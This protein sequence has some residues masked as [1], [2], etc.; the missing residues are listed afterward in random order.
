MDKSNPIFIVGT[1]RSGTTLLSMILNKHSAIRISPETHFFFE[2]V[3]RKYPIT[4]KKLVNQNEI[5]ARRLVNNPL[6]KDFKKKLIEDI[7]FPNFDWSQDSLSLLDMQSSGKQFLE[8][9]LEH[10]AVRHNKTVFGEKTPGH[11]FFVPSIKQLF[12]RAKIVHIIRDPRAV[13][14]STRKAWPMNSDWRVA[15]SLDCFS[16]EIYTKIGAYYQTVYPRDYLEMRYETLLMEPER[17]I[18]QLCAFLN[19]EFEPCMVNDGYKIPPNFSLSVE[20]WK[21]KSLEPID[22]SRAT[23]WTTEMPAEEQRFFE[24]LLGSKLAQRGFHTTRQDFSIM[25]RVRERL[26]MLVW[27]VRRKWDKWRNAE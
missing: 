2:C 24:Q 13:S 20:P 26:L 23:A 14:L 27:R 6:S 17:S 10:D 11:L 1:P 16:W 15:A 21:R 8:F 22:P 4:L 9:L 7:I 25:D 18:R 5:L 19:V 12:P 3:S